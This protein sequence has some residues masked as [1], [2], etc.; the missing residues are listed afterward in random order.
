[1]FDDIQLPSAFMP[2]DPRDAGFIPDE[3]KKVFAMGIV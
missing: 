2:E 1:V 3:N